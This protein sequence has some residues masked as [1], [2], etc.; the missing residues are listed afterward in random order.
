MTSYDLAEPI[1]VIHTYW[2]YHKI[3]RIERGPKA[4]GVAYR[5]KLYRHHANFWD[6]TYQELWLYQS[7]WRRNHKKR[8]DIKQV[9]LD[10]RF[11]PFFLFSSLWVSGIQFWNELVTFLN[12]TLNMCLSRKSK[13]VLVSACKRQL[14]FDDKKDHWTKIKF[15]MRSVV[16]VIC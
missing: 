9:L 8:S 4:D 10:R 11:R 2:V 15:L 5:G 16:N 12:W 14:P 3:Q 7:I 6:K 1:S 13:G